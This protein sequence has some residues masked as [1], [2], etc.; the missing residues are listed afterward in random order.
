MCNLQKCMKYT[1]ANRERT[2]YVALSLMLQWAQNQKVGFHM[3][4]LH[5]EGNDVI[6][7]LNYMQNKIA[8][9]S[10][11]LWKHIGSPIEYHF[12]WR[13]NLFIELKT[14]WQK[15]KLL[16]MINF[17]FCHDGFKSRPLLRHQK[18]SIW[19]KGLSHLY[20]STK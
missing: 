15:E 11:R 10:T 17:S 3:A 16:I 2:E 18:V 4:H 12:L 20:Q 6:N 13:Y 7:N 1:K 9:C 19:R 8:A 14:L 5:I